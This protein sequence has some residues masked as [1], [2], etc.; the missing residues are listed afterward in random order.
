MGKGKAKGEGEGGM[1]HEGPIPI[2]PQGSKREGKTCFPS[3]HGNEKRT[4]PGPP[5][6]KVKTH[7]RTKRNASESRKGGGTNIPKDT[8]GIQCLSQ[9][10][11]WRDE[12]AHASRICSAPCPTD[13]LRGRNRCDFECAPS[14]ASSTRPDVWIGSFPRV[15]VQQ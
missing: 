3:A 13:A 2:Q 9:W 5:K 8:C 7:G 1:G 6:K 15:S 4:C 10:Q 11:R 14:K 12:A